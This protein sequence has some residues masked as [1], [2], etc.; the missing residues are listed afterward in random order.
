MESKR[1][2]H[3]E[4]VKNEKEWNELLPQEEPPRSMPTMEENINTIRKW[5]VF[6]GILTVIGLAVG[7]IAAINQ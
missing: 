7:I 1:K 6:F 3:L 4:E 5:V 2:D